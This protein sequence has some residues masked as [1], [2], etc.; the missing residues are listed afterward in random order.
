MSIKLTTSWSG[1]SGASFTFASVASLRTTNTSRGSLK[2][3]KRNSTTSSMWSTCS[4]R[5]E[6]PKSR[7]SVRWLPS[8]ASWSDF[9]DRHLSRATAVPLWVTTR[10]SFKT[11]EPK[12]ILFACCPCS[13]L[14]GSY[15]TTPKQTNA[16]SRPSTSDSSKDS[17]SRKSQSWSR[18]SKKCWWMS[19]SR[20]SQTTKIIHSLL[21]PHLQSKF[22]HQESVSSTC[23]IPHTHRFG[24]ITSSR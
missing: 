7:I 4:E 14:G 21:N 9:R 6:S 15:K 12:T 2:M 10:T 23:K 19:Q 1:Y 13:K 24:V 18:V 3:A 22:H 20:P 11:L 17:T 5:S 16:R 8:S